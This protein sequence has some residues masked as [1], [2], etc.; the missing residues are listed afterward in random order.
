LRLLLDTHIL[1]WALAARDRLPG[2]AR[3]LIESADN[4]ILA[5]TISI[6]EV[7]IKWSLRRGS[8]SDIPISG[9]GLLEATTAAEV[10]LLPIEPSH[11]AAVDNLPLH[12]RDPFDRLL[13]VTAQQEG[14]VLLTSDAMLASYGSAVKAT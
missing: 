4:E 14:A 13:I 9:Q 11:A 2:E 1:L 7:A 8:I 6:W 5:S 10:D 12:H 3:R